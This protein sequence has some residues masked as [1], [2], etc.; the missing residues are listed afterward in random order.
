MLSLV[1]GSPDCPPG[2]ALAATLGCCW[3]FDFGPVD[4]IEQISLGESNVW[5]NEWV[6]D[7]DDPRRL[8][9]GDDRTGRPWFIRHRDFTL[10]V[11]PTGVAASFV[12]DD[13]TV[14]ISA[15]EMIGKLSFFPNGAQTFL[16]ENRTYAVR[17]AFVIFERIFSR[18][19][20]AESAGLSLPAVFIGDSR[21]PAMIAFFLR[22]F[23][24]RATAWDRTTSTIL[25]EVETVREKFE[26]SKETIAR[27]AERAEREQSRMNAGLRLS[28]AS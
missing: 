23:G 16:P 10:F 4:V 5:I 27:L 22:R 13:R 25:G 21:E 15:G 6:C 12:C 1:F 26:K 28:T 9:A 2:F 8:A 24:M 18:M 20:E 14:T 19:A 11:F 3:R 7:A 17:Q